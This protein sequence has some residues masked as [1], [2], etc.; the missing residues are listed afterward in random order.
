MTDVDHPTGCFQPVTV[1]VQCGTRRRTAAQCGG[2]ECK[3]P[4]QL[5]PGASFGDREGR[6]Q[7]THAGNQAAAAG[8]DWRLMICC[9]VMVLMRRCLA[10]ERSE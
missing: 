6:G 4:G 3:S 10:I 9:T 1:A 2:G 7:L 5:V 8:T